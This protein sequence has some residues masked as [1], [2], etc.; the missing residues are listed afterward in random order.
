[1]APAYDENPGSGGSGGGGGAEEG[2]H[3]G[4]DGREAPL[5]LVE[6]GAEGALLR[7]P[8]VLLGVDG[9]TSL[10]GL[11]L[12]V[13]LGLGGCG[14]EREEDSSNKP[15]DIGALWLLLASPLPN[16]CPPPLRRKAT[17]ASQG[18]NCIAL[19]CLHSGTSVHNKQT[20]PIGAWRQ[21]AAPRFRWT[22]IGPEEGSAG[23]YGGPRMGTMA[24]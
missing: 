14:G 16:P 3:G 19:W 24:S 10:R 22:R 6:E 9:V 12:G 18:L 20:S 13:V 4:G 5:G 11:W 7:G 21:P 2:V 8:G 1:M 15:T 17:S 23:A